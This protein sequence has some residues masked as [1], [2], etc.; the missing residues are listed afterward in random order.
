MNKGRGNMDDIIWFIAVGGLLI[1]LGFVFIRLGL[2]IWKKQKMELMI[3]YHCDKVREE[4]KPAYCA[5]SGIGVFVIGIGFILSGIC[6]AFVHSVFAFIPM[7]AGL[8]AGI[9]LLNL[10]GIRYNR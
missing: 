7:A 9:A 2:A 4:N 1:L 3:R 10:A 5:L 8:A 6:S